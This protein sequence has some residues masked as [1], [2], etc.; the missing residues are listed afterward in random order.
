MEYEL[1][2]TPEAKMVKQLDK[3]EMIFQANEY[4][5]AQEDKDLQ[6]F[7]DSTVDVFEDNSEITHWNQLLRRQRDERLASKQE[8]Q[9]GTQ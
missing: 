9:P 8:A 6:G 1:L 2:E 7:F 3:F 4:E 5:I